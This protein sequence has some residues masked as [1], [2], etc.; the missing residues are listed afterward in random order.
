MKVAD[1]CRRRP[2][3][4]RCSGSRDGRDEGERH[5]DDL[6]ARADAGGSSAR[7]SALV[8]VLTAMRVLGAAVGGELRSKA[9]TSRRG[10]TGRCRARRATAASISRLMLRYWALRSRKGIMRLH[11]LDSSSIRRPRWAHR[12]RSPLRGSGRRA[13]RPGRRRSAPGRSSMQSTKWRASTRSASV[14]SSCGAH[15][16]P[17]R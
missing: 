14:T 11:L 10:R 9:A 2:A 16:S 1:R 8:P 13:G 3:A 4:R 6:V 7:C 5:G 15:M 12:L 17:V